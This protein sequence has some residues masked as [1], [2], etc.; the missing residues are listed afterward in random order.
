MN[1]EAI[2]YLKI[3][4]ILILLLFS[5]FF[6]CSETTLFSLTL[7]QREKIRGGKNRTAETILNLLKYPGRL[8]TTILMGND[9]VNIA[10]SVIATYLFVALL[11]MH[12]KWAAVC[13]MTPLTMVFAEI[14]PKTIGIAHNEKVAPLV[15]RPIFIFSKIITPLRWFFEKTAELILR[16]FGIEPHHPGTPIMEDDFLHMVDIS[17][18]DGGLRG[19][20]KELIHNVFEFSDTL[21]KEVMTPLSQVFSLP[22]DIFVSNM[23]KAVKKNNFSRIPIYQNDKTNIIG[24]LYAKDLLKIDLAKLHPKT[25]LDPKIFR[26]AIFISENN[27]VDSLF[28]FLKYK[29]IHMAICINSEKKVTGLI[30]MEDLLEALFGEIYDEHDEES[31]P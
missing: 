5:G 11:G 27:N 12:G 16:P 4:T 31:F 23:I 9:L 13:V 18:E 26:K 15:A 10:A 20:E 24:I 17:H 7:I 14:I 22:H 1:I 2:D 29:R 19:S 21:V 8:I 30:A 28:N 25:P 3:I 6:S